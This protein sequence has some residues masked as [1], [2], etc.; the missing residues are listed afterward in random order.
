M[1]KKIIITI[2][3]LLLLSCITVFSFAAEGTI[4]GVTVKLREQPNMEG[5]LIQLLSVEDKVE[6]IEKSGDWY[7]VKYK[8]ITGYIHGDYLKVSEE[9]PATEEPAEESTNPAEN[10]EGA[11]LEEPQESQEVQETIKTEEIITTPTPKVA[12]ADVLVHIIPV[13]SSSVVAELK[14]DTNVTVTKTINGWAYIYL[15]GISGW[16]RYSTLTNG[17]GDNSQ[18]ITEE[19]TSESK[20]KYISAAS[21]NVREKPDKSSNVITKV[22]LNTEIT[23]IGEEN[24]WSKVTVN[25][26]EG[27]IASNLLSNKKQEVTS[28]SAEERPK[29]LKEEPVA[30]K[31]TEVL[32]ADSKAN[33]QDAAAKADDANASLGQQ[34]VA[35]AKKYL[36]TKY[37]ARW[38]NPKRI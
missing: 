8:D 37:V 17:Q 34:I 4:T 14:K 10:E 12:G 5:K 3:M 27:Y 21:V 23:V 9:V 11:V 29:T 32:N 30:A 19:P 22:S 2:I 1:S 20:I 26:K 7:Q 31:S 28:R 38:F 13:I 18:L 33:T 35:Y 24:E 25:G 36:G 6:V 15:E 16:I